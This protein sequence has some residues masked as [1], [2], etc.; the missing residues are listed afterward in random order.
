MPGLRTLPRPVL[1]TK[2]LIPDLTVII[3]AYNEA[4]RLPETLAGLQQELDR[5][6]VDYEVIVVD[7]GSCDGTW[8]V[9]DRFDPRFSCC[10][11]RQNAGK[12]AAV[13]TGM[14][15]ATGRVVAFTDADLPFDLDAL[16]EGYQRVLTQQCDVIC[17]SRISESGSDRVA[18]AAPLMRQWS[19]F[20]FRQMVS[21]M[22]APGVADT[23]CGLK[24]FS[25]RS[26]QEIFG[27]VE[28][29]GFAFD[30]EVICLAE[31]LGFQLETV[32]VRLV[33]TAGSTIS[34][35]RHAWPMVRELMAIR[36]RLNAVSPVPVDLSRKVEIPLR[37]AA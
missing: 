11:L 9:T 4:T 22:V 17:G 7:D 29:T 21:L 27:R 30:V 35:W 34:L 12:G 3:P 6:F 37:R 23:Q 13:R 33:N 15:Q 32:P 26:A 1:N 24:V 16:H 2:S 14:L 28:A 19:G 36:R 25:Q 5:W 10:R 20:V 18:H 8:E 31:R